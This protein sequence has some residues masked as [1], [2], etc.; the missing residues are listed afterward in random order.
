MELKIGRKFKFINHHYFH[1]LCGV[2]GYFLLVYSDFFFSWLVTFHSAYILSGF[3][4][5][6]LQPGMVIRERSPIELFHRFKFLAC[7]CLTCW[8]SQFYPDW[9]GSMQ[10]SSHSSSH[11][12]LLTPVSRCQPPH[13]KHK[14]NVHPQTDRH[15]W[16]RKRILSRGLWSAALRL[17]NSE[18]QSKTCI[19]LP[20][21]Q[22][23]FS[24]CPWRWMRNCLHGLLRIKRE[25]KWRWLNADFMVKPMF[26][27][28]V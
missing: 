22:D 24:L 15:N 26:N 5:H 14:R 28:P 20:L 25:E 4:L 18:K 3:G 6:R 9:H 13:A 27:F 11:T 16:E 17:K 19:E 8:W 21:C 23:M 12:T 1:R 7:G 2:K 10:D